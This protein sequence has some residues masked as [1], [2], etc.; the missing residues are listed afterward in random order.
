MANKNISRTKYLQASIN[1][2]W[3]VGSDFTCE[4]VLCANNESLRDRLIQPISF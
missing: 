4:Y 3:S 2:V 1:F